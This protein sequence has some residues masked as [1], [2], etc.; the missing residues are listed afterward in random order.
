MESLSSQEEDKD[1]RKWKD[2]LGSCIGTINIMKMTILPKVIYRFNT[3]QSKSPS[4]S[5]QKK[6]KQKKNCPKIHMEL[7]KTQAS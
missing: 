3:K 6:K 5:S 7:E 4:H 2:I 1:T